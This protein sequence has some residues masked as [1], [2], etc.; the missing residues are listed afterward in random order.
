MS[1]KYQPEPSSE[2]VDD[3]S[4]LTEE[5]DYEVDVV[6]SFIADDDDDLEQQRPVKSRREIEAALDKQNEQKKEREQLKMQQIR[7]KFAE[8]EIITTAV[9]DKDPDLYRIPLRRGQG[10]KCCMHMTQ[11][12]A[13]QNYKVQQ[14]LLTLSYN[15]ISVT[16][17]PNDPEGLYIESHNPIDAE[18]LAGQFKS[19]VMPFVRKYNRQPHTKR[20][21]ILKEIHQLDRQDE[22]MQ[23]FIK[24]RESEMDIKPDQY[25]LIKRAG[26]G[27]TFKNKL[28]RVLKTNQKTA[29]AS[30]LTLTSYRSLNS[31]E[32]TN[33][34]RIA[35]EEY[36]ELGAEESFNQSVWEGGGK[37]ENRSGTVV[38]VWHQFKYIFLVL[39]LNTVILYFNI[40]HYFGY[41]PSTSN[42]KTIHNYL[43]N[44]ATIKL[45]QKIQYQYIEYIMLIIHFRLIHI[46]KC[47]FIK[48]LVSVKHSGQHTQMY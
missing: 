42:A 30:V 27:A 11:F 21:Q 36:R 13:K 9:D 17:A 26:I 40:Q 20:V 48:Q 3:Q 44:T 19:Y 38:W 34:H 10:L 47:R 41:Q 12:L 28:C 5:E 8:E 7:A 1:K 18:R 46:H 25:F 31:K 22:Q 24:K 4:L 45:L 6:D 37:F 14:Q 39:Q 23:V 29:T 16:Y 35:L 43:N 32:K 2:D 15:V 33:P